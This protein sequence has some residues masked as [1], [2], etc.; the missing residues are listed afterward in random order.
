MRRI[1]AILLLSLVCGPALVGCHWI[2]L[3]SG[4]GGTGG[5][6]VGATSESFIPLLAA[7]TEELAGKVESAPD[8]KAGVTE[9][10]R[11]LD[12]RRADLT[13]LIG[14]V[15]E[16]L[17]TR[18]DSAA[19]GKWLEAEVDNTDRMHRLQSKYIDASMR[20]PEFK[21][22]LDKLVADYDSMFKDR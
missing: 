5:G 18:E 8:P 13:A 15:K 19:R 7:F 16:S 22:R 4:S 20:D 17:R 14:G 12:S 3:D 6:V 1:V 21:A 9:A 2:H 11:L 10:Q